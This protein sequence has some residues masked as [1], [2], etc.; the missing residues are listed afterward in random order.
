MPSI[1]IDAGHG[2]NDVGD[3]FERRNEKEDNLKLAFAVGEILQDKYDYTVTYTRTGDTYLTQLDRARI[4]NMM[5]GDLLLSFHRIVGDIPTSPPGLGFYIDEFGGFSELVANNIGRELRTLGF[6]HYGIDIRDI[7]LF[8]E[9]Q[10][11]SLLMSIGY[12]N[13][14]IDNVLFDTRLE[15]IAEAIARG[16][17]LSFAE[18]PEANSLMWGEADQDQTSAPI[19]RIRVG[20]YSLY[21]HAMEEQSLLLQKG[22]PADIVKLKECYALEVGTYRDLDS[23]VYQEGLLQREGYNPIIMA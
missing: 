10:M 21:E 13:S 5:G 23:A 16:V 8:R 15:E 20:A 6:L 7:P 12:M 3:I 2:G 4:A 19:Y 22:Y 1:I 11:P 18:S 17:V 14:E 9:T